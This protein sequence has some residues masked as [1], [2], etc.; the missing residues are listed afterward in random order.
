MKTSSILW[1]SILLFVS[2]GA[3]CQTS[4]AISGRGVYFFGPSPTESDSLNEDDATAIDDFTY[5]VGLVVPFLRANNLE[6]EYLSDKNIVV[7]YTSGKSLLVSRDSVDFGTILTD[8]IKEP[9]LLKFVLTDE[10]LKTEVR[11]YFNLK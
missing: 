8:G 6:S 9:R 3:E 7:D 5:Y 1:I 10:E 2:A 4:R 11:E